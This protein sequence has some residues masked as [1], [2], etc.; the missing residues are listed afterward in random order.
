MSLGASRKNLRVRRNL[1]WAN[2]GLIYAAN[3]LERSA[4]NQGFRVSSFAKHAP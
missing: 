2:Q 3:A 4:R 1:Y